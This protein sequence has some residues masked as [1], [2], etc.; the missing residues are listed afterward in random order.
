M[1]TLLELL[2]VHFVSYLFPD[3]NARSAGHG[4]V[5]GLGG[6]CG[7]YFFFVFAIY[8]HGSKE[9]HS[10]NFVTDKNAPM[11]RC[12]FSDNFFSLKKDPEL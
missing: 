10:N 9:T 2:L 8:H 12:S 1:A 6:Q 3:S 5:P 4:V 11:G 7:V